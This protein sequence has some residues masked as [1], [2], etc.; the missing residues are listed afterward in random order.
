M[1]SFSTA[2][3]SAVTKFRG[4]L[5]GVF[6]YNGWENLRFSIAVYLGIDMT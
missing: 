4:E 6:K 2:T 1:T 5:P 3:A